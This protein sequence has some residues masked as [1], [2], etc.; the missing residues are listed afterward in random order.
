MPTVIISTYLKE[1]IQLDKNNQI[2]ATSVSL[3]FCPKT[4]MSE[5]LTG[6]EIS[7]TDKYFNSAKHKLY[8]NVVEPANDGGGD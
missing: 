1:R 5:F 7:V 4:K 6:G 2:I 8:Y 3:D